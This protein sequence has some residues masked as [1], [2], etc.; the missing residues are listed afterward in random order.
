LWSY[1]KRDDVH[2]AYKY[3]QPWD[4]PDNLQFLKRMPYMFRH[5]AA[6]A[7]VPEGYTHYRVVVSP[8]TVLGPRAPFTLG[9]PGPSL[10]LFRK[11][12]S[13][14]VALVVEAAE[15]VPWTKPD[16]LEYTP[17]GPLPKLGGHFRHW[18][19]DDVFLVAHAD[20]SVAQYRQ[21]LS[22]ERLRDLIT[23]DP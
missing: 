19:K 5:P 9:E 2:Y 12:G 11:K 1:L 3:D 16:E 7:T 14:R 4:S 6:G 10:A 17:G 23:V 13:G 22:E 8:R 18:F 15:A 20:G 21:D